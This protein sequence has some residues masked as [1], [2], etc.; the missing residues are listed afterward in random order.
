MRPRCRPGQRVFLVAAALLAAAHPVRISHLELIAEPG[1]T[2]TYLV[3]KLELDGATGVSELLA[4]CDLYVRTVVLTLE[5]G[6]KVELGHASGYVVGV[7]LVPPLP[8]AA[9]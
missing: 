9:N 8:S 1:L 2:A 3:F 5:D 4:R 7:R 6:T